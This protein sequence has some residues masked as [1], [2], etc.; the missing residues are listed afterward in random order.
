[1][2]QLL[3]DSSYFS[4]SQ[5]NGQIISKSDL[6][7]SEKSSYSFN[8]KYRGGDGVTFTETVNLSLN[9]TLNSEASLASEETKSL[10]IALDALSSTK[11][12]VSENEGGEFSLSGDDSD[13]FKIDKDAGTITSKEGVNILKTDGAPLR[14]NVNYKENNITHSEAVSL[15]I[16]E[17]LQ[18]EADVTAKRG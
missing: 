1:M 12:Y 15:T 7:F 14:F 6:D 13:K 10:S 9:D 18:S 4:I 2:T 5:Y 11:K 17:A 8:V 16:T 3:T